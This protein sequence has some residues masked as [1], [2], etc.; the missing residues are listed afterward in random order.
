MTIN[1]MKVISTI[2]GHPSTNRKHSSQCSVVDRNWI[3]FAI[4]LAGVTLN[5]LPHH[6]TVTSFI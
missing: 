4:R 1:S 2:S 3:S 6:T 5:Y